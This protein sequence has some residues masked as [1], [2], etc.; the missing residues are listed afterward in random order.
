MS[1]SKLSDV[2]HQNTFLIKKEEWKF[3]VDAFKDLEKRMGDSDTEPS[4]LKFDLAHVLEILD[5][6]KNGGLITLRES[7]KIT[8]TICSAIVLLDDGV[9]IW[10]KGEGNDIDVRLCLHHRKHLIY[11]YFQLAVFQMDLIYRFLNTK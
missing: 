4:T 1:I 3:F 5:G 10:V 11:F 7:L 8:D 2:R 6:A 9:Q